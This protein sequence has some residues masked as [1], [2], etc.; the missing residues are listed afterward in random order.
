MINNEQRSYQQ[1]LPQQEQVIENQQPPEPEESQE[2]EV[3]LH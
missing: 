3:K 2:I 1:A